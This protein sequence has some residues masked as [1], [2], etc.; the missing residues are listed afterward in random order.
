MVTTY[1][2]LMWETVTRRPGASVAWYLMASYAYYEL[3]TPLLSDDAFDH[4]AKWM[5][6]RWA[7]I[8]HRHKHLITEDDLRAGT[9]LRRDFPEMAKGAVEDL[10][11]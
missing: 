11:R 2:R 3:D 9:L 1:D 6:E 4:L 8:Q 10:L 7:D 5:L